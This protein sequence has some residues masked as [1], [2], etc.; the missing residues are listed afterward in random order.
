M[1]AILP[2]KGIRTDRKDYSKRT[3]RF[4]ES[5]CKTCSYRIECCGIATKFKKIDEAWSSPTM[6]VCLLL[7]A[8]RHEKLESNP[9]H[10]P[11]LCTLE[12]VNPPYHLCICKVCRLTMRR[13]LI[14][15]AFF[16]YLTKPYL[17]KL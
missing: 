13:L 2:F 17:I 6:I 1:R 3:Y 5:V 10:E 9:R 4:S 16:L 11:L 15:P 8:D 14:P 7:S 12:G